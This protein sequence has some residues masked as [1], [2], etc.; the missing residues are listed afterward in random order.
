MPTS[1]RCEEYT[2]VDFGW[3]L[4]ERKKTTPSVCRTNGDHGDY[5]GPLGPIG[6]VSHRSSAATG[7]AGSRP[8][9]EYRAND[10]VADGR[11]GLA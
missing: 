9:S 1:R 2:V 8:G 6:M 7:G 5:L 3:L 10:D 4:D 11:K